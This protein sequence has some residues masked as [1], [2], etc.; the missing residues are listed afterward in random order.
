VACSFGIFSDEPTE[1]DKVTSGRLLDPD[2]AR[3]RL[4]SR[5]GPS[6]VRLRLR[7]EREHEA[8]AFGQ[9]PSFLRLENL[10]LMQAR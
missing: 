2:E 5:L 8:G 7:I 3:R 10:P 4:E 6:H 9:G 1:A